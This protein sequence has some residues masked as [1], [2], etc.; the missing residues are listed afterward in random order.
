MGTACIG[1][2]THVSI[3]LPP[4]ARL[5]VP[6]ASPDQLPRATHLAIG[7]LL[8]ACGLSDNFEGQL[9]QAFADSCQL[10]WVCLTAAAPL[11]PGHASLALMIAGMQCMQMQLHPVLDRQAA[12]YLLPC[13]VHQLRCPGHVHLGVIDPFL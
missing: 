8:A 7:K 6:S 9:Q 5:D 11:G 4:P 10:L 2:L 12:R 3:T 1:D 13:H